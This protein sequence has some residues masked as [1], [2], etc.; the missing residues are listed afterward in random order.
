MAK[1][2]PTEDQDV[3]GFLEEHGS[4][5]QSRCAGCQLYPADHPVTKGLIQLLDMKREGKLDASVSQIVR[6]FLV[7]RKGITVP[8]ETRWRQHIKECLGYSDLMR[9]TN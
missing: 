2:N 4:K 5:K 1:T 7:K 3:L 9:R 6:E 8:G